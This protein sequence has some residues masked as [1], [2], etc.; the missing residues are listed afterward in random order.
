[1]GKQLINCNL[2]G[3]VRMK[4]VYLAIEVDGYK[5]HRKNKAQQERDELKKS[6]LQ[7]YDITLVRLQ[8][9]G[10]KEEEKIRKELDKAYNNK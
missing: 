5:N 9:D 4:K 1:M 7:K 8:T 10:S 3:D 6:I 2:T